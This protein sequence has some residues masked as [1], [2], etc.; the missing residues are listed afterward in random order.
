MAISIM[1]FD[2]L[3]PAET[4]NPALPSVSQSAYQLG[5]MAARILLDRI[6]EET[7]PPKY[8]VLPTSLKLR[9]SLAPPPENFGSGVMAL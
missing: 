5:T 4:T 2:D 8:I 1:R 6:D 3:D 7:G 9:E